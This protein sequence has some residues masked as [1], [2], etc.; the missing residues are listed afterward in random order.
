MSDKS[1][2][3]H[4]S[5]VHDCDP[6]KAGGYWIADNL[7]ETTYQL[8]VGELAIAMARKTIILLIGVGKSIFLRPIELNDS[9]IRCMHARFCVAVL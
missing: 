8:M 2:G 6:E 5:K 9:S 3:I 7:L 1:S 4:T